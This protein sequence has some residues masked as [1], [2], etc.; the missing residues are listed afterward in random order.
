MELQVNHIAESTWSIRNFW[1]ADVCDDIISDL[2]S[3]GLF[4]DG[5]E[6][7]ERNN[8]LEQNLRTRN[9]NR[10]IY[11]NKEL[12]EE[13]W[14]IL[15]PGLC[16][17]ADVKS[18]IGVNEGCRFYKYQQGQEFKFHKDAAFI[19]NESER[20]F[21]SLLIYLNDDFEG[22]LTTFAG[23]SIK[24]VKGMAVLFPHIKD[25]SSTVILNGIKYILRSDIMS[26]TC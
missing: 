10:I 20:S 19:R 4:S 26:R 23:F 1:N 25:H 14:T 17:I 8:S 12:A 24:P 15:K 2:E 9:M 13:I 7:D 6:P 16:N 5:S 21:F 3:S 18:P 11:N 22:G